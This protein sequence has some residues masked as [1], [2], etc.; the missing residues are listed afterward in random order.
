MNSSASV[1][2][3]N[4]LGRTAPEVMAE[5]EGA[6]AR[7]LASGWFVMG[8]E[9]NAFEAELAAYVGVPHAVGLGNGT[10][11]L[12]LALAALG[13][14]EGDRVVTVANAGAYST[15]AMRLL[16]AVPLFADVDPA[17]LQMTPATFEAALAG[18]VA[19][20][21]AVVVTHLYGAMADVTGIVDIARRHGIA[22]LEDCA[23][24][25]GASSGDRRAGTFGDIATT[26]FYP[27]K[28]LGALG[29]GGAVYTA[30]ADLADSVRRMR[31]YGWDSKYHIAFDHGRNSRLDELQAAILRV[32]LP[33][34]DGYNERRRHIHRQYEA[35]TGRMV[36]R[37][38]ESFI[39]HLAVLTVDDREGARATLRQ[40][41]VS[42]DVHYPIA[43]H[44]QH[45][46]SGMPTGVSLQ[47]TE[48]ATT[49]VLSVPM[50]PELTD[51]EVTRV[52]EG[53]AA[54]G[55]A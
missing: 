42:T 38:S 16:G 30:D 8:P 25:L 20:P 50:F 14:G 27:T 5:V 17:T 4:D 55:D 24:A 2:P 37:A 33:L 15:V 9:H 53:L 43:D 22:V 34:L 11:A 51:D 12:E 19:A 18:A 32:K 45:F 6:I 44:Q 35:A 3:F 26:S 48:R 40:H 21:R 23:Q 7:V 39:A 1:V 13:V 36:N 52:S 49:T 31:Q 46:P 28:N 54:L 10:D 41:G 29:D 47:A